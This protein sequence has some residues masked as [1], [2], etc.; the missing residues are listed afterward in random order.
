MR[1][2]QIDGAG[3]VRCGN[4]E[5]D[6]ADEICFVNPRDELSAGTVGAAEAVA[7]EVEEDVE[8]SAGVGAK[9]HRA[10]QGDPAGARNGGGE[11]GLFPGFGDLDGEV[12]GVGCAGFVAAELAGGLVHGAIEGVAVD[13]G[14]A[15]VEP[16][17]GRVIEGGDDLV[18]K[19]R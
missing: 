7:D 9:G 14:G 18:E 6:G 4:E 10:A 1:R 12:P 5:F 16:D 15:G 13:G 2:G 19:L 11:E 3:K 17:G 8:D